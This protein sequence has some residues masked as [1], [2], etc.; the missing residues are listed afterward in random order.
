MTLGLSNHSSVQD[1]RGKGRA[2]LS[3]KEKENKEQQLADALRAASPD[4]LRMALADQLRQG[5]VRASLRV[6]AALT[7]RG[8][9][10]C[11]RYESPTGY[12]TLPRREDFIL[13]ATRRQELESEGAVVIRDDEATQGEPSALSGK[14]EFILLCAD[15]QWIATT[16]PK[17]KPEWNRAAG[18]FDPAKLMRTAAYLYWD[19]QRTPGQIAKALALSEQQQRECAWIQCL[20]VERWKH[21]LHKRQAIARARITAPVREGDKRAKGD[22]DTT[23][24]RRSDLWLCA[25]LADWKPQRTAT[26][27]AMKTG[28]PLPRNLVAKQLAKLPK[29]RRTDEVLV[30]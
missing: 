11:F 12:C 23:I 3:P 24:E 30:I 14:A 22:Q 29:V 26:L 1:E 20:H 7:E 6:S 4:R 8:V 17:H 16:Y 10:P 5:N 21:R 19:G 13:S 28:L 27:Y 15:L 9:A 18:I 25:E 2:F